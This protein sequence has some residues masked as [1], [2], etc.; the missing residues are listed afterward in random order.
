MENEN[1][2]CGEIIYHVPEEIGAQWYHMVEVVGKD[3]IRFGPFGTKQQASD[4]VLQVRQTEPSPC[5]PDE[6]WGWL[7]GLARA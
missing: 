6:T 7:R 5:S 3:S 2:R 1:P 4:H